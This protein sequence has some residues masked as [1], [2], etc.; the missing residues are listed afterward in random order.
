MSRI[1][2]FTHHACMAALG[3]NSLWHEC[4][5]YGNVFSGRHRSA[6]P[7]ACHDGRSGKRTRWSTER[8]GVTCRRCIAALAKDERA[9]WEARQRN[10]L[11]GWGWKQTYEEW[12]I[13]DRELVKRA[14]FTCCRK[15]GVPWPGTERERVDFERWFRAVSIFSSGSVISAYVYAG[16]DYRSLTNDLRERFAKLDPGDRALLSSVFDEA[17]AVDE[18]MLAV[19]RRLQTI[20]GLVSDTAERVRSRALVSLPMDGAA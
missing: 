20:E 4:N 9:P 6:K 15:Q 16:I 8:A 18:M 14:W 12:W 5:N 13:D 11:Y 1:V 19:Q 17:A 2:H 7:R 10:P 3:S